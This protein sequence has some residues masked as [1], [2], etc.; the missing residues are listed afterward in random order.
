LVPGILNPNGEYNDTAVN[1]L[2]YFNGCDI[3]TNNGTEFNLVT[4]PPI[5]QNFL[6][7][8]GAAPLKKNL[9]ADDTTSNQYFLMTHLYQYFGVLLGCSGYST[10]GFPSYGGV[11][12][13]YR[14]HQYMAL[15]PY[16]VGYFITQVGLAAAS[17]GVAQSDIDDVATALFSLFGYKCSAPVTV[18]PAQG[19][20]LDSICVDVTC[21]AA[22][23]AMCGL[24]DNYDGT[25][26]GPVTECSC[27]TSSTST[28]PS[29]APTMTVT[30]TVTSMPKQTQ[31][32]CHENW[33]QG[34]KRE[35][36]NE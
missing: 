25:S 28:M 4:N 34:D 22:P 26:P 14:V 17:F 24:Y 23:N 7:G 13:M 32:C 2:P 12:S 35:W 21:A 16:E 6:D 31:C 18:V 5:S 9:P 29:S 33:Q 20:V 15:D 3:S 19:K 11:G 27:L 36:C 8:G 10:P 1:L 30:V